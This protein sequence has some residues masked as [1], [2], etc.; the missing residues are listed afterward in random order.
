[1]EKIINFGEKVKNYDEKVFNER[2]IR[3]SAGVLFLFGFIGFIQ[4]MFNGNFFETKI[5]IIMFMVDFFIRLFINPKYSPSLIIGRFFVK[6]QEP[7]YVGAI[8]KRFAWGL[9]FILSIIMFFL[10]VINNIIGPLNFLICILCLVLL[11]FESVFGI[12]FGCY[13]YNLFN[14]NKAKLC[15]GNTCN[16]KKKSK[17]QEISY[18][19]ILIVFL[20]IVLIFFIS[21][22]TILNSINNNNNISAENKNI[23]PILNNVNKEILNNKTDGCVV[24]QWAIDIGHEELYKLHHGCN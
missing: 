11:F 18:V 22:L 20:F 3:A 15:P 23:N 24:P 10:L 8:Q 6:N 16:I 14:K 12:C 17:I 7:E 4:V 5:F 21:N 9:G 1:M 19:Q 2:E 13:T